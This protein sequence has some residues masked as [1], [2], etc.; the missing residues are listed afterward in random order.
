[1]TPNHNRGSRS[2]ESG[3]SLLEVTIASIM[4]LML[5]WLVATLSLDGMRAQKY[6]ERTARVTEI[7]QDVIDDIQRSLGSAVGMF[8]GGVIGQGYLDAIDLGGMPLPI[9]SSRIPTFDVGGRLERDRG[10]AVRTGNELFFARYA[11]TEIGRAH[12]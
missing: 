11:W 4:L 6:S 10:G 12:V 2:S 7:T 9:R 1:M 5:A 3:F 8:G